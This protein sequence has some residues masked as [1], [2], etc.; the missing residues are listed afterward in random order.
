MRFV[1]PL[2][3]VDGVAKSFFSTPECPPLRR[4]YNYAKTHRQDVASCPHNV[5]SRVF[6]VRVRGC[7]VS[8]LRGVDVGYLTT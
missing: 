1:R 5:K 6:R 7:I 3:T 4:G 2:S 8:G